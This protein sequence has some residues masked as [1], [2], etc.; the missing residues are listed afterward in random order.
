MR[1][2]GDLPRFRNI[3]PHDGDS[4][5]LQDPVIGGCTAYDA[6][7]PCSPC[8]HRPDH[9]FVARQA[10]P[11]N[12]PPHPTRAMA[13]ARS[14]PPSRDPRATPLRGN[15]SRAGT[16]TRS[17]GRSCPSRA[18]ASGGGHRHATRCAHKRRAGQTAPSPSP[19]PP[20][21]VRH[22]R[23][24]RHSLG[25][26]AADVQSAAGEP[27]SNAR[28]EADHPQQ[29]HYLRQRGQKRRRPASR[30][31]QSGDGATRDCPSA[32]PGQPKQC[33]GSGQADANAGNGTPPPRR[34]KP[35]V[36]EGRQRK[37][38]KELPC[39]HRR[40]PLAT[41]AAAPGRAPCN[42][43]NTGHCTGRAPTAMR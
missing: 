41:K 26:A 37:S 31:R 29:S 38:K 9:V 36:T 32:R 40:Q 14:S 10:P 16:H 35:L 34:R 42:T 27:R 19:P 12:P 33:R 6:T 8:H 15:P 30:H 25:R 13:A 39:R 11:R 28:G 1:P 43:K 22:K 5:P 23:P 20:P 4:A 3:S 2:V 18:N 24:R 21:L 17:R 7:I